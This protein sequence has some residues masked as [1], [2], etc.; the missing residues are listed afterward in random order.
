MIDSTNHHPDVLQLS[1][2]L[3]M[4]GCEMGR[5]VVLLKLQSGDL[6]I[7][8]TAPFTDA[9]RR[10]IESFGNP[11]WMME[12]TAFH[13]TY[14]SEASSQFFGL[15][16]LTP[17]PQ[18]GNGRQLAAPPEWSDEIELLAFDGMPTLSEHAVYHRNSKTLILADL[19]FNVPESSRCTRR[20]LRVL[21]GIA[22]YP[23]QSRLLRFFIRDRKAFRDSMN[24]LLEWDFERIVVGHGDPIETDARAKLETVLSR[25]DLI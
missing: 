12:A 2:S 5:E 4:L 6:L 3:K 23:G 22:E 13:D 14:S 25:H 7:H 11:R 15:P 10:E 16:Y 19:L 1:F 17:N 9:D 18:H 20:V 21:S 24:R 8:S